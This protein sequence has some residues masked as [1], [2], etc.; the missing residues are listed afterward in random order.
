[1]SVFELLF[2]Y[3][4]STFAAGS[5]RFLPSWPLLLAA[6]VC[7]VVSL[8]ALAR[9][10]RQ[11]RGGTPILIGLRAGTLLLLFLCLARPSLVLSTVVPQESFVGVLLDSSRSMGVADEGGLPRSTAMLDL[12]DP[13]GGDLLRAL[14]ERFKVR[15]FTFSRD[16]RRVTN[17]E[18]VSVSG[19]STR[20][21]DAVLRATDELAALPLAGLVVLSDGADNS[22]RPLDDSLLELK[23]R[24]VPVFTVGFGEERF[25]R[26]LQI[27]RVEAPQR[28]LEGSSLVVEVT[29]EQSGF[30]GET[31]N[32]E[33][34]DDGRIVSSEAL[35]FPAT[36]EAVVSRVS[37]VAQEA[38]AR[39]FQFRVAPQ[40]EEAVVENNKRS[41]LIQVDDRVE[42][43]LYFEGEPR[44]GV[45]FLRRAVADDENLQL[46]V[47]LR[48]AEN[49]FSRF[50]LDNEEELAG[51]FPTTREELFSYRGLIL[52]SIEASF[53]THDQLRMIADF[54]GERG[55]GFMMLGGRRSFSEGGWAG[56]PVAEMLPVQLGPAAGGEGETFRT[57]LSIELT[58]WGR[59]HPALRLAETEEA[60]AQRWLELPPTGTFNPLTRLKPG[61]TSLIVGQGAG[62]PDQQIV[63][64]HQRYGAGR[65][66]AWSIHDSWHWQM[67]ADIP[68]EDMT[69]E[70]LWRQLLRWLVSYAPRA[71]ELETTGA[72]VASGG[73]VELVASVGD[74]S[75]VAVNNAQVDALVT[76]PS[77][78]EI[79][80]PLSWS[81]EKDGEYRGELTATEEGR[82]R[83]RLDAATRESHLGQDEGW[84]LAATLNEEFFDAELR[85]EW[86]QRLASETGG[87]YFRPEQA[88]RIV[89]GLAVNRQ[90]STLIER[91]DL[92]DMP[93][94]FVLLATLLT[95]EWA[96]R[97]REGMA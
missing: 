86:L 89:D 27:S 87:E 19:D 7:L 47:L 54:A 75:F 79:N 96:L 5:L 50:G 71:V 65:S 93:I 23:A 31:V 64:A 60:S 90:G 45:K 43:I 80:V 11:R 24:G 88:R 81:V 35:H 26:D 84:L 97:R 56:T 55:G 58:P 15:L 39:E 33:V 72:L 30:G 92:W 91:R 1:M 62:I 73:V 69:H 28:V 14:E 61:A 68:V 52:G 44:W 37:F 59:S 32:L 18:E 51:G 9:Y 17:L 40:R 12:L 67:S 94:L 3:P 16:L 57:E 38:G 76:S 34:M 70:T 25:A 10:R 42:K 48:T 74:E 6:A 36:G 78:E 77:G 8:P 82:Y 63:L 46:V 13:E 83:V 95:L 2:K 66:L 4:P 49:R 22:A 29:V 85:P 53:F 21:G 20:L 41:A